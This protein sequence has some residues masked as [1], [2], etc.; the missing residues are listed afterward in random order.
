MRHKTLSGQKPIAG[1]EMAP[2]LAIRD[3]KRQSKHFTTN[4]KLINPYTIY[5]LSWIIVLL[6]YSLDWTYIYPP[7]TSDLLAFLA[8]TSAVSLFF[9]KKFHNRYNLGRANLGTLS[10]GFVKK[11]LIVLYVLLFLEFVYVGGIPI[12]NSGL[13]IAEDSDYAEFGIPTVKVFVVNGFSLMFL[14]SVTLLIRGDFSRKRM[15]LYGFLS[16]LPFIL[17]MQRGLAM[18]AIV[19]GVCI[20]LLFSK[21]LVKNA[22]RTFVLGCLLLLAFGALGQL[23]HNDKSLIVNLAQ[24]KPKFEKSNYP[25]EYMWPYIY[26]SSPLANLQSCISHKADKVNFGDNQ[27][28][29][30]LVWIDV[31]P[32]FISKYYL[33]PPDHS[34]FWVSPGLTVGSTYM[35]PFCQLGYL[36]MFLMFAYIMLFFVLVVKIVPRNSALFPAVVALLCEVSLFGMFDNMVAYGGIFPQFILIYLIDRCILRTKRK[37]LRTMPRIRLSSNI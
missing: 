27:G 24:P 20:A 3:R 23:R 30:A 6:V 10:E 32:Q 18:D 14:V 12:V 7:L 25:S 19:G 2:L 11:S 33:E 8:F 28:L 21:K 17:C 36:G 22:I 1:K 15:S 16:I 4:A 35:N 29:F 37:R 5:S 9:A 13:G 34:R 26:I 31:V